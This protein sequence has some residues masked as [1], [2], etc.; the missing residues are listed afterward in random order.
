MLTFRLRVIFKSAC[1]NISNAGWLVGKCI[2]FE[3]GP[4]HK[5]ECLEVAVEYKLLNL[6][7]LC[8]QFIIFSCRH[9][10]DGVAWLAEDLK[11]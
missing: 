2:T 11:N 10:V 8:L 9:P 3:L 1:Y 4:D 5:A 6:L 7:L